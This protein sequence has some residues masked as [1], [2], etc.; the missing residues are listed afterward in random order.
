[1]QGIVAMGING[2][3]PTRIIWR[4]LPNGHYRSPAV[5][6]DGNLLAY[7]M[8]T[9]VFSCDVYVVEIDRDLK[10]RANLGV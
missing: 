3:E 4:E 5:S 2:G 8:C 9:A 6:P 10:V 7:Y 1:M